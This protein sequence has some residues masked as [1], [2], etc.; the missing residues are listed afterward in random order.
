MCRNYC[1][2]WINY[3]YNKYAAEA[4]KKG[5][6]GY[7]K[8]TKE[9]TF[10]N[11]RATQRAFFDAFRDIQPTLFG[12]KPTIRLSEFEINYP[13]NKAEIIKVLNKN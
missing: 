7:R 12:L 13:L 11:G 2:G 5:P 6:S 9:F 1:E 10:I 3:I 4:L 8:P